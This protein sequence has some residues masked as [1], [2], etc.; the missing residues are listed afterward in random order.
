M[1]LVIHYRVKIASFSYGRRRQT[2][3]SFEDRKITLFIPADMKVVDLVKALKSIGD[4]SGIFEIPDSLRD[5]QIRDTRTATDLGWKHG[6]E[7]RL[8]TV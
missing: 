7:L 2:V 6:T 5:I 4:I 8:D 1:L 3:Y